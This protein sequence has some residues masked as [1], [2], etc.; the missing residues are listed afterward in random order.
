LITLLCG[1][2]VIK[3]TP[4]VR[5]AL[6]APFEGR[7]REVG[8]NALYAARLA[9]AEMPDT[10]FELLPVDDGGT[11]E[12]A[13]ERAHA[14]VLDKQIVAAVVIG[15]NPASSET[16]AAF[17]DV[18]VLIVGNWTLAPESDTV[19]LLSRPDLDTQMTAPPYIEVTEAARLE[20]PVAGGEVFALQ[21]FTHLRE[22]LDG[23]S[24]VS[25]GSLPDSDFAQRYRASDPFAPAPGL[26]A[27]LTYDAV[28][29]LLQANQTDRAGMNAAIRSGD[30]EGLNG[31]FYFANGYWAEA[32]IHLYRYENGQLTTADDI[33]E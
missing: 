16:L 6:L 18:P 15:Y 33:V 28:R 22:S 9:I 7:Y 14:L 25:S 31:S 26:L 19:F 2:A 20:T 23:I 27:T 11:P 1:C 13:L 3:T 8:Y 4:V 10:A 32:P 24:V 17:G 21:G 29:I 5:V 12:R 30:F